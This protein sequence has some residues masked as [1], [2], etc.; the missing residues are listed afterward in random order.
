M[1][2]TLA[3]IT[4]LLFVPL[5]WL[6]A[7]DL[8]AVA[9]VTVVTFGDST[10]A[11]RG[12]T[13]VYSSVLQEELQNVRV[14]N[15]GLGGNTTEMARKRFYS[16]VL[17]HRP[18]VA[19]IQFGINDAAVDVWKSPPATEPRV[20]LD[21]YEA[22]LRHFAQALKAKNALVVIMTSNPLRW[23]P[24]L[25]EMYGKPPYQPG[26]PEGFNAPLELYCKAARKVAREEGAEL[27]DMQQVFVE[28]AQK[29]GVTVDSFL[30]DGMHP[31][32]EGHR[33]EADCLRDCIVALAK[34]HGLSITEEPRWRK[35]G[36]FVTIHPI[37]SDITHD[38]SN[39][40]VFGCGLARMKD[41]AVMTVY[42]TPSS[43]YSKPGTTWI[44]GRVATIVFL[45][46]VLAFF[47]ALTWT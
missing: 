8:P 37:C 27:L 42:S 28:E 18:Q 11:L 45:V 32:D 33:I 4:T 2:T 41:G 31:N 6:Q 19:I 3:L 16:D 39:P 1:K 7:T 47:L 15:S 17:M 22:N 30:S 35:S 36:E 25:K 21:R 23:T 43:P 44:A 34:T 13:K 10:T 20:S 40:T 29:R 5:A 38:S 9:P 14:I 24:K 12:A 26:R 46:I